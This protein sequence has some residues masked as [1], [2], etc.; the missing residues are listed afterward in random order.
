MWSGHLFRGQLCAGGGKDEG[1]I[2]V[3][4]TVLAAA[5]AVATGVLIFVTALSFLWPILIGCAAVAAIGVIALVILYCI[6]GKIETAEKIE[7]AD[8]GSDEV[9]TV[10]DPE[11]DEHGIGGTLAENPLAGADVR[12][13]IRF[14]SGLDPNTRINIALEKLTNEKG[15]HLEEMDKTAICAS[16]ED[17]VKKRCPTRQA[18]KLKDLRMAK[19]NDISDV[20]VV[21]RHYYS[22]QAISTLVA[23]LALISNSY[24]AA[25]VKCVNSEYACMLWQLLCAKYYGHALDGKDLCCSIFN[26]GNS[27]NSMQDFLAFSER[28]GIASE[29][30]YVSRYESRAP[31]NGTS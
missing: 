15:F 23:I 21:Y 11:F 25:E 29:Y 17:V 14:F 18:C 13:C 31:A 5:G 6:H 20:C 2:G 1:A 26:R 22:R 24:I 3:T 27:K 12:G 8:E 7:A 4:V 30:I 9:L 10:D 28:K 19:E 16:I